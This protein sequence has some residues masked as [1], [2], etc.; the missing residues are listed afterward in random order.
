MNCVRMWKLAFAFLVTSFAATFSCAAQDASNQAPQVAKIEPP[1]WWLNLTPDV[2]LLLS[3]HDLEARQVS[4]NIP[5]VVVSRT[6]ATHG[7]DYLFVWLKFASGAKSGTLVCRVTTPTGNTTFELPIAARAPT[8][9]RF[10]GLTPDDIIYLIMPD[11]FANGD[12]TNDG[13][14]EFPG[15]HDRAKPRAWHGGD[16]RGIRDHLDYL[17]DLRFG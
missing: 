2:M 11:R 13:P 17:Q 1:N 6:Q 16:L 9:T 15:S 12:P 3:G 14:V 5:E 10:H 8:A 4:C 7:G